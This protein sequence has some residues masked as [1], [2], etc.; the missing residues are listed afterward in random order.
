ME[1]ITII[2]AGNVGS[3]C[4]NVI[5]KTNL[6]R[7][8]IL[9]DVVE[10]LAEGKALDIWQTSSIHD[11]HTRLTGVTDDYSKT[12]GS[13]II[14]ITCGA[15]RKPGMS[16]DDLINT[17]ADIVKDVTEKALKYSPDAIIIVV[18]NPLDVMTYVAYKASKKKREKVFGMSSMLDAGRFETFI[19]NAVNISPKDIHSLIIGGHGDK[20]V[21]LTRYTYAEGIPVEQLIKKTELKKIVEKTKKGGEEILGLIGK[22]A[23]F[24]SGAAIAEMAIAVVDNARRV[25]PVCTY[26]DGEYGFSDICL[27]V[28]VILGKNGI[29]KIIQIELND[30]ETKMLKNSANAVKKVIKLLNG[31]HK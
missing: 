5:A 7:E 24:A 9:L 17:N 10:G 16:R 8:L 11:F 15:S 1:K 23:W 14:I 6:S 20:I 26:L 19:A 18:T 12:K 13:C 28:P 2:G 25:F 29:E 22:S 3:T 31:S 27:G 21:P 4:A 30:E